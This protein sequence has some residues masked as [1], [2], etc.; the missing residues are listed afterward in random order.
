MHLNTLSNLQL[1]LLGFTYQLQ[2]RLYSTEGAAV[3]H[4]FL[5]GERAYLLDPRGSLHLFHQATCCVNVLVLRVPSDWV[6]LRL[7]TSGVQHGRRRVCLRSI[8]LQVHHQQYVYT[9][10]VCPMQYIAW[11]GII[12]SLAACVCLS[13]CVCARVLGAE[14]LE[15]V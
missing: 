15:N 8:R 6:L 4:E 11:D 5:L 9:T 2:L 1:V 14:Y 7:N 13:V 12:K 10:V 3:S